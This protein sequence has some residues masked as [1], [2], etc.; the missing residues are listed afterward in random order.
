MGVA[1]YNMTAVARLPSNSI[2]WISPVSSTVKDGDTGPSE[3]V[4]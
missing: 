1:S 2:L 3:T 4:N